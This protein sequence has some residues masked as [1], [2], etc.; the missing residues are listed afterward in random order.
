MRSPC[1]RPEPSV[2]EP[3]VKQQ[4]TVFVFHHS[5]DIVIYKCKPELQKKLQKLLDTATNQA[6]II[7]ELQQ[8]N[9]IWV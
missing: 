8:Y 6:K 3:S 1:K 4:T 5:G 7:E 2:I 9:L